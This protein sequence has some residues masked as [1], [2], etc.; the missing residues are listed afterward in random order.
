MRRVK[1]EGVMK[2]WEFVDIERICPGIK[3]DIIYATKNNFTGE[4]HYPIAKC[5]LRYKVAHKLAKVQLELEKLR[6]G[7]KIFD[8]YRPYRVTQKFWELIGDERY[9]ADPK[10][11]SKHNRGAAVD[12][13]LIDF[14]GEELEMPTVVDEMTKRAHRDYDDLP[15][16]VIANRE[17]LEDMMVNGGFLPLPTEWWH[18]DDSEWEKYPIENCCLTELARRDN[19]YVH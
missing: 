6:L 3:L 14:D 19:E 7:L 17:L 1:G 4:I 18:F 5:Y 8:G 9:V 15:Q 13:T 2:D 10:E 11:G 12:V 16:H